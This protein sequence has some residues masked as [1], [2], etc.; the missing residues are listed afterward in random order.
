MKLLLSLLL[1]FGCFSYHIIFVHSGFA[2]PEYVAV[3]IKQA[4]RSNPNATIHLLTKGMDRGVFGRKHSFPENVQIVDCNAIKGSKLYRFF[5]SKTRK[6]KWYP[7]SLRYLSIE[8]FYLLHD[9]MSK[10]GL[11]KV[12]HL[13]YDNMLYV[14]LAKYMPTISR[15]YPN[16]AATSDNDDRIIAGLI[17]FNRATDVLNVAQELTVKAS[18]HRFEMELLAEIKREKGFIDNLPIVTRRY[19]EEG[20]L[21]NSI[22]NNSMQFAKYGEELPLIFDACALGQYVGGTDGTHGPGF[23][24]EK[25]VIDPSKCEIVW[26]RGRPFFAYGGEKRPIVNLHIHSK[27]LQ[28]FYPKVW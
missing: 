28:A 10:Y 25:A 26:E 6:E 3:A 5:L 11:E 16:V 22:G 20:N 8:R 4:S 17:Y 7:R 23:I 18:L 12:F 13:E 14:D 15:L 19:I 1:A 2:V 9:Y 27:N 24:N 21:K